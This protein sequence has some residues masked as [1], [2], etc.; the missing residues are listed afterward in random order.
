[1]VCA[2]NLTGSIT[3]SVRVTTVGTAGCMVTEVSSLKPW[4]GSCFCVFKELKLGLTP[5]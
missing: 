5:A 1:M 4:K 2:L 3:P